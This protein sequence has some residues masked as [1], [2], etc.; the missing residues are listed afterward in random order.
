[1]S[2]TQGKWIAITAPHVGNFAIP[3]G[4]GRV[5]LDAHLELTSL[6][7]LVWQPVMFDSENLYF[8][9]GDLAATGNVFVS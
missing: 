1:M 9:A 2:D 4:L 3:H 6:S 8:Q 7:T 5:P